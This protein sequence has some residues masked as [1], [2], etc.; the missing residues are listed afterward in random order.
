MQRSL[1]EGIKQ[2]LHMANT[3][4]EVGGDSR[5]QMNW[6]C[7][8]HL[9]LWNVKKQLRY[10]GFDVLSSAEQAMPRSNLRRLNWRHRYLHCTAQYLW[11]QKVDF[12]RERAQ[13]VFTITA[14][15]GM[16]GEHL[17][18]LAIRW[19]WRWFIISQFGSAEDC[20]QA[21]QCRNVLVMG[22]VRLN[23]I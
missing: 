9:T 14:S 11:R 18:I 3:N 16:A 7:W 5:N 12:T 2:V 10:I 22:S 23:K 19:F 13:R 15:A 20:E 4:L 1:E 8:S 6:I 21:H 17:W